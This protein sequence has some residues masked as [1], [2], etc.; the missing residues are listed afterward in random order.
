[1]ATG[2]LASVHPAA[3]V[4]APPAEP[5][6]SRT[7]GGRFRDLLQRR[8]PFETIAAYDVFTA[9]MVEEMGFPAL[10]MGGSLTGDFYAEPVWLTDLSQRVAYVRHIADHVDIPTLVDVDDGGDPLSI[11]RVTRELE[12]ARAGAIHILDNLPGPMGQVPGLLPIE[13]MIDKIHAA[14][15]S[16]ADL[17]VTVRCG[18]AAPNREG[19]DKAIERGVK[20]AEAGAETIWFTGMALTDMPAVADAIKI[21]VTAQLRAVDSVADAKA[22]RVTCCVYASLLQNIAQSAVY[23]ALTELKTTGVMTKTAGNPRTGGHIPPEFRQRL[24]RAGEVAERGK[25]YNVGN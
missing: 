5:A 11:Y 18:A 4:P 12:R 23:D 22:N 10:F 25:K 14:V 3:A 17:C 20:Y 21:P 9:R 19:R 24:M 6:A 16:R 8:E 15:D 1:M 2:L 13:K 7:M